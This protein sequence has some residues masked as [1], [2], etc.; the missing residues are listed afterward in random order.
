MT[1]ISVGITR[2]NNVVGVEGDTDFGRVL[3]ILQDMFDNC[4][5]R[6]VKVR[7]ELGKGLDGVGDVRSC[8][9]SGIHEDPIAVV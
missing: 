6:V 8:R 2:D 5:V 7:G 4:D 3:Q 1:P 9:Y